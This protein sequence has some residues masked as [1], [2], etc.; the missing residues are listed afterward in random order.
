MT[1]RTA[2]VRSRAQPD[3]SVVTSMSS[4]PKTSHP[5]PSRMALHPCQHLLL[6]LSKPLEHHSIQHPP[7]MTQ[8]SSSYIAHAAPPSRP[9]ESTTSLRMTSSSVYPSVPA[10]PTSLNRSDSQQAYPQASN[11]TLEARLSKIPISSTRL[12]QLYVM[13][14]QHLICHD[15]ILF[16]GPMRPHQNLL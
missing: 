14:L 12:K 11:I 13:H 4:S 8:G 1:H 7:I 6:C 5:A 10:Y 15:L 16:R 2:D 3:M 9:D